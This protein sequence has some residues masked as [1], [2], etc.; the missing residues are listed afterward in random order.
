MEIFSNKIKLEDKDMFNEYLT[1]YN[2][3]TSGLSF[4]SLYMWRDINEMRWDIFEDYLCISATGYLEMDDDIIMPFMQMP[5]TKTGK[6]E[7]ESLRKAILAAKEKTEEEGYPFTMR[8]VPAGLV[9]ELE[10]AFPGELEVIEDRDNYDYLYEKEN[11]IELKG[12]TLHKKKNHMNYFL[13]NYQYEYKEMTADMA[14]DIMEFIYAFNA[15]KE[16]TPYERELLI[17]EQE[18]MRDVFENIDRAG[19]IGGVIYIDG[20]IEAISVGGQICPE[21]VCVHIEKANTK[22]RGLYQIINR[23]YCLH[24]PEHIKYMNREEDMGLPGLRKSKMSYK[25]LRMVEKYIVNFKE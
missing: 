1:S 22:Y 8:L 21:T 24:M 25:P 12:R 16:T 10:K 2:Y 17:M 13:K 19:Y 3:C 5:L 4:S 7:T 11:L 23:E 15:R 6:Y 20:K 14:D 9:P 18:A